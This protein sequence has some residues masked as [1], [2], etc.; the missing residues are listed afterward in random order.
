MTTTTTATRRRRLG[1]VG[2]ETRH[3]AKRE[4]LYRRADA[5]AGQAAAGRKDGEGGRGLCC[6]RGCRRKGCVPHRKRLAKI[7]TRERC[8]AN[9]AAFLWCWLG[10]AL[11]VLKHV[12]ISE[13]SGWSLKTQD[14]CHCHARSRK[15]GFFPIPPNVQRHL[16]AWHVNRPRRCL[17][18]LINY[19]F[20]TSWL[21]EGRH[22]RNHNRCNKLLLWYVILPHQ[23]EPLT[24]D[25]CCYFLVAASPETGTM[26]Q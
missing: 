11:Q 14:K 9:C 16:N 19:I 24:L 12:N 4:T 23:T 6:R 26:P 25:C 17:L 20:S 10:L 15:N 3:K 7:F 8:L 13:S 22:F 5:G 1:A 2:G 21:K 18:T